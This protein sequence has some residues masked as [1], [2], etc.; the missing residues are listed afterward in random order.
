MVRN[1][2]LSC[3]TVRFPELSN[4]AQ[5]ADEM[6]YSGRK[7]GWHTRIRRVVGRWTPARDLLDSRSRELTRSNRTAGWLARRSILL[8]A[9]VR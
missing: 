7:Y 9:P 3:G 5:S 4:S 6:A 2:V 8:R 1:H